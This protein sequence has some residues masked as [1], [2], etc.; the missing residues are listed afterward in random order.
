MEKI[1]AGHVFGFVGAAHFEGLQYQ[2]RHVGAHHGVPVSRLAV[3]RAPGETTAGSGSVDHDHRVRTVLAL[4]QF[5]LPARHHIRF[6]AGH[7]GNDVVDVLGRIGPL[8][9]GKRRER[10]ARRGGEGS[11]EQLAAFH[12]VSC[13]WGQAKSYCLSSFGSDVL[14][15]VLTW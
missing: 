9:A 13:Y 15:D 3:E 14:D 8:R 12:V 11:G 6:A 2:V 4:K 10:A 7:K 1:D 5:T